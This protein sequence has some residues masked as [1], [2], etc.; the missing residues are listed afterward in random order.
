MAPA[1]RSGVSGHQ[2]VIA[3]LKELSKGP[4]AREIDEAAIESMQPMLN[5]TRVRL[6]RTRNYVGKYPGFPQ[7]RVPRKGG[8]VDQGIVVRK[9]KSPSPKKRAYRLGATKRSRYLL[10]LVELG[11]APHFQPKFR[12]GWLHPGA[13]AQPVLIPTFDEER[14]NVPRAFGQKIWNSMAGRIAR[15]KK[16]PRRPK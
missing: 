8:H 12:G 13:R 14:G 9:M 2:E 11:T 7:P 15:L 16:T 3:N 6:R 5:K 4:T 1:R 10:H